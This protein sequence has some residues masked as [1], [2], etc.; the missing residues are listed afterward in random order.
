MSGHTYFLISGLI[1]DAKD[2]L[3][4]SKM[5][6]R[7]LKFRKKELEIAQEQLDTL[8]TMQL[9]ERWEKDNK[10]WQAITDDFMNEI[11]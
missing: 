7:A 11:P 10:E 6:E 9:Q 3:D 4:A 8:H 5:P 2:E 1:A